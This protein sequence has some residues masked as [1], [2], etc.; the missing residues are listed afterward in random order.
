MQLIDLEQKLSEHIHYDIIPQS[1]SE[2]GWDVRINEEFPETVIRFGNVKFEGS[3][4]EDADGYLSFNFTIVSSPDPDLT[5]KDLT[6]QSYCGRILNSIIEQSM[7]EGTV[8]ARDDE[9]GEIMTNNEELA[10]DWN[11]YKSG[12]DDTEESVN[13]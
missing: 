11:E 10:E 8:V 1:E 13:E 2:D 4:K 9:T 3:G 5:E 7:S 12:T 6:L